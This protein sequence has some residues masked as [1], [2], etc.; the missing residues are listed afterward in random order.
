MANSTS[1]ITQQ[2][3][4]ALE[5]NQTPSQWE[6]DFVRRELG[7]DDLV[8]HAIVLGLA[9]QLYIRLKGWSVHTP[10]RVAAKLT[11]VYEAQETRSVAIYRQLDEILEACV[12][13][14][15]RPLALKGVHLAVDYYAKAA[16]RPMND[17]DLL[18]TSK[19]LPQAEA[20]L[21]ELGYGGRYKSE[22]MGA[23]VTKHTS[24]FQR[25]KLPDATANPYLSGA[26]DRMV[27]PH[28]S[29]EESW[30]GLRVD[31]TPGVWERAE[32]AR[33]SGQPCLVLQPE[34]L[35]LHLCVHF[36]FH[37]IGGAPAFVQLSDLLV[38][39]NSGRIDWSRFAAR[40]VERRAAPYALAALSLAK[41]L[42]GAP[43]PEDVLLELEQ[44]T[45]PR[46]R[47]RVTA[48]C[49]SDVLQRTQQS[50]LITIR[51]RIVRGF[52]DRAETARWARDLPDRLRIWG[53]I[54]R[55]W[56]TDTGSMIQDKVKGAA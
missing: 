33:L 39:T 27:E 16:L 41:R 22:E 28:A 13:A 2:I 40:A 45:P 5:P 25:S 29:L 20:L 55:P 23:G 21:A 9:P 19:D 3:L 43:T 6:S 42:L 53:T 17:I 35:L 4:D 51:Q 31:I 46:L 52:S 15:L 32:E 36:C 49:L 34:D 7:W 38:V 11:A 50:P 37:L 47:Q 54:L 56:R 24:T 44:S 26:G 12:A 10:P 8:V 30:F 48:L 18:F 1:R 14:N